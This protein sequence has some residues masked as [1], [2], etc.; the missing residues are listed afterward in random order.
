MGMLDDA[1]NRAGAALGA[2]DLSANPV[3]AH[4]LDLLKNNQFGGIGGLVQAFHDKG[5]GGIVSSWIG[6]GAN[7]PISSDQLQA[8]LGSA[9][10]QA[11]AAKVGIP[12][13]KLKE[14]LTKLLPQL[15]D[16]L[17][18]NGHLPAAP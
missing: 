12:P 16:K 1:V 3:L 15:V 8:V 9:Q 2:S 14:E 4:A 7:L 6:T 18:P 13:D 5:F 17:S 10:L 11:I